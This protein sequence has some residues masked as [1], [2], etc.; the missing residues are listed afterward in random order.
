M[1][2]YVIDVL[3]DTIFFMYLF[4]F[5]QILLI[6]NNVKLINVFS[7]IFN[8]VITYIFKIILKQI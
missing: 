8:Y 5:T 3:I 2:I 7:I 1:S 6:F 4:S